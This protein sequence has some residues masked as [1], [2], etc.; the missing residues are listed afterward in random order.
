[1][2][3]ITAIVMRRA[4][5]I[6]C[7]VGSESFRRSVGFQTIQLRRAA[8]QFLTLCVGEESS[9]ICL[10]LL[11]I[12]KKSVEV[13]KEKV[14]TLFEDLLI[15]PLPFDFRGVCKFPFGEG[16]V[17]AFHWLTCV[18]FAGPLERDQR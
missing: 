2:A 6:M 8:C 1:M 14:L 17:A 3:S 16:L 5:A 11:P 13:L 9:E 18:I 7:F 15:F 12:A 4:L 10:L